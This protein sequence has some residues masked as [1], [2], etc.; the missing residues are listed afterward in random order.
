MRTH[1]LHARPLCGDSQNRTDQTRHSIPP[2]KRWEPWR[3]WET[4]G[5]RDR[6]EIE[7]P[8][9]LPHGH[10]LPR[11]DCTPRDDCPP[12]TSSRSP[13]R[14]GSN[15]LRR[16]RALAFAVPV[17]DPQPPP[18]GRDDHRAPGLLAGKVID[19]YPETAV[20]HP[21]RVA[22]ALTEGRAVYIALVRVPPRDA[23]F[24]QWAGRFSP[25]PLPLEGVGP[26]TSSLHRI[27]PAR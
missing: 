25:V 21:E 18:L 9:H 15:G 16:A 27:P 17:R 24:R 23:A 14:L 3:R 20:T 8:G 6:L 5:V 4:S 11:D 13:H 1:R 7:S 12:R 26:G 10:C 2:P 22:G 19:V